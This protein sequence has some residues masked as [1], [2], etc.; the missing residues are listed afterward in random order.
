MLIPDPRFLSPQDLA[1]VQG[2]V[3]YGRSCPSCAYHFFEVQDAARARA[4]S[5]IAG[6]GWRPDDHQ[7]PGA[8]PT[9]IAPP[10]ATGSTWG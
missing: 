9:T 1:E 6:L 4:S 8:V 3:I 5:R 2:L 7:M 10:P